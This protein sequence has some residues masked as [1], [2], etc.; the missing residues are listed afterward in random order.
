MSCTDLLVGVHVSCIHRHIHSSQN[1]LICYKVCFMVAYK[2]HILYR[3]FLTQNP[4]FLMLIVKRRPRKEN[5][6]SSAN[7]NFKCVT[8]R[9]IE[10]PRSG[11]WTSLGSG[12]AVLSIVF[13][14]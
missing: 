10:H 5:D 8:K 3:K 12:F 14:C 13:L 2:T 9:G 11:I 7:R 4:R 6:S 1:M